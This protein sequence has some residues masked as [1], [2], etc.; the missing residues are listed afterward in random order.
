[1]SDIFVMI[2]NQDNLVLTSTG[3]TQCLYVWGQ[4]RGDCPYE[5]LYVDCL[6]KSCS[7]D[8]VA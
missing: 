1:M 7:I 5:T 6:R 3:L 8:G 2:R 4:P